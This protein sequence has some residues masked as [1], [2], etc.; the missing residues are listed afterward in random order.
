MM[1]NNIIYKYRSWNNPYHKLALTENQIYF[2]RPYEFN[3]PFDCR[4]IE[5]YR[6]LSDNERLDYVNWQ[7]EVK[8]PGDSL[9]AQEFD[10]LRQR[11]LKR[12]S[13]IEE[14]NENADSF[15]FDSQNRHLGIF[16]LSSEWN[17][18]LLWSHY[19][20][21]HKGFCIGYSFAATRDYLLSQNLNVKADYVKY[22]NDFPSLK[23]TPRYTSSDAFKRA[24]VQTHTKAY[25][26]SYEKE[27]RII[28]TKYPEPL[29]DIERIV[30][31]PKDCIKEVTLGVSFNKNDKS[32]IVDA[33]SIA[34]IPIYQAKRV[35]FK[36]SIDRDWL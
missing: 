15:M 28:L 10:A 26:W 19:A 34:K 16:C 3:D 21:N 35:P 9:N 6:L 12:I 5:N 8:F 13:N 7:I 25:G 24:F 36:Y 30:I 32:E 4:I 27:F 18:I 29:I 17:N 22:Q 11:L 31:L 20:N 14:Y 33:C 23:P 1:S 2:A